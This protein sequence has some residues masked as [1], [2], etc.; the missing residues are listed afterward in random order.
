[1]NDAGP[2]LALSIIV[3]EG[4]VGPLTRVATALARP[5]EIIFVN[6]GSSDGTLPPLEALGAA[7]ARLPSRIA[8]W[9]T[10]WTRAQTEGVFRI[11]RVG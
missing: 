7:D 9:L 5:Y 6:D 10:R 8:N 1:M 11:S 4:N 2:P 3:P